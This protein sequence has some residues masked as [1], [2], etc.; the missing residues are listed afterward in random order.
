MKAVVLVGGEGTRMRPLT[1][2]VP[3][4]LLPLMNRPALHQVLDH[5]AEHGLDE[6]VLSSPYLEEA[7]RP[8]IDSRD[9]PPRVRW[10]TEE[11]PLGTAGAIVNAL[12]RVG[13]EAFLVLNGDILTDLDLTAMV[14]FHRDRGS[15]ATI[16][17]HHVD[18]ARPFG[19]V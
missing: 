2:T 15:E 1:E 18:D 9:G 7:F 8:F 11:T 14:A 17:L 13:S 12:P 4:P 3:K 10:I 16:A 6:V 19:L 5:L